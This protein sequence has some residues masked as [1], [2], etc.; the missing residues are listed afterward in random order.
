MVSLFWELNINSLTRTQ[1]GACFPVCGAESA[2]VSAQGAPDSDL[3][4]MVQ[5]LLRGSGDFSHGL[6]FRVYGT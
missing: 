5:G 3:G 4:S 6:G 2:S 1:D